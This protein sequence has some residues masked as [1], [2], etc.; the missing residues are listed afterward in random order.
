VLIFT[1]AVVLAGAVVAVWQLPGVSDDRGAPP[2]AVPPPGGLPSDGSPLAPGGGAGA[3][4]ALSA[5]PSIEHSPAL[6]PSAA[7]T[8]TR[9]ATATQISV[10]A[11]GGGRL[12]APALVWTQPVGGTNRLL[13]VEVAVGAKPDSG[14][15]LSV[16]DNGATM[17]RLTTVH[18]N[19]Q[20]AG[21]HSVFYRVAP[22][23]GPNIISATVT[24]CIVSELTGGSIG[25]AGVSQTSPLG[26]AV[27]ASGTGTRAAATVGGT[28]SG[29]VVVGFVSNGSSVDSASAPSTTRYTEN[30]NDSTGAGNSAAATQGASGGSNTL[31]WAVQNGLVGGDSGQ[32]PAGHLS[33]PVS[34]A[35]RSAEPAGQ[36]SRFFC[37]LPIALRGRA[38]TNRTRRGR[39]WTDSS[40]ATKSIS[41]CSVTA[42]ATTYATTN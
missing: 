1:A 11:S 36:L 16:S 21:F 6:V 12:P 41:C 39:L 4:P 15:S 2:G 35:C 33:L 17:T 9:P 20:P 18:D 14:C 22:P 34:R 31:A 42:S 40:V 3:T 7:I 29:S 32:R 27:T 5:A 38:S 37:T 26:R 25:F 13:T 30:G 8:A 28:R 10:D 24:G 19:N 23:T